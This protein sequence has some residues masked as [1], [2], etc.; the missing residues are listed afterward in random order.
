MP[1]QDETG[2][3]SDRWF[4][5]ALATASEKTLRGVTVK[6]ISATCFIATKLAAFENR[7]NNDYFSHD[8]ED[9]ITLIDGRRSVVEE[10][11][12][13]NETLKKYVSEKINQLIQDVRFLDALPGHM[14]GDEMQQRRLPLLIDRLNSIRAL[15]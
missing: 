6:T 5:Y 7:G 1:A 3:F 12:G 4:Q 11:S 13:E 8:I 2:R 14:G 9:I 10:L 15:S